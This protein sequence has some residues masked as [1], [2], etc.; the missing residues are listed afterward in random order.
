MYYCTLI[1]KPCLHK[2]ACFFISTARSR[3]C[4]A[5][6]KISLPYQAVYQYLLDNPVSGPSFV[7]TVIAAL[8]PSNTNNLLSV[9]YMVKKGYTVDFG[10]NN[11]KIRKDGNVV[12]IAERKLGL[13]VLK[14]T[15]SSPDYQS[16]HI[17][18]TL[19]HMWHKCLG[20]AM[21]WSIRKLSDQSIV[22]GLEITNEETT[23]TDEHCIPYLKG[24]TTRNVIP[25]KSDVKNPKRL[26]RVFSDVCGPFDVEGYS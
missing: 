21:T 2:Q 15:T 12:G 14:G 9:T 3:N 19:L 23:D 20:Y 5:S 17:T 24:K 13:W 16:A 10:V 8:H 25:K 18:T 4:S 6:L 26:H 11:C 7:P 22:T 1:Y